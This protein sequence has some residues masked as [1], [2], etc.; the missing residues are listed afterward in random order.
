MRP[1]F[2]MSTKKSIYFLLLFLNLFFF[3]TEKLFS[4]NSDSLSVLIT[5]MQRGS[6]D[7]IRAK[8][9]FEF[10]QRLSD[11]I[12][13]Y[14]T[15]DKNISAFKNVSVLESTDKLLKI[16]TYTYPTFD[17]TNYYYFGFIQ[18]RK[19][20]KDSVITIQLRDSTASIIKPETEKL[21]SQK[22]L[23]AAYYS[24]QELKFKGKQYYILLGW[25][26]YNQTTTKKIIEVLYFDEQSAKFGYSLF[27]TGSVYRNRIVFS[28]TSQASMSLKFSKNGKEI[29]FDHLSS[30]KSKQDGDIQVLTGPDGTY[31]SFK[32][33]KGRYQLG[34]DIDARTEDS[35][36]K[37]L[38][39]PP[40]K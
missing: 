10:D 20:I 19:S 2:F 12:H 14:A 39:T 27:K 21:S 37:P 18:Y 32:L 28:F 11:S 8:A 13:L 9:Q 25:K 3:R 31:D 29:V 30:P 38:P 26:G 16:Y 4:Q 7:L 23:G 40:A 33:V 34:K 24:I 15:F 36:E 35:P 6:D 22:W 1:L 5:K 17:G